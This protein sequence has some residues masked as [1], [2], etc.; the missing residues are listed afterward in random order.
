MFYCRICDNILLFCCSG[1]MS[2]FMFL[3]EHGD[4]QHF[5]PYWPPLSHFMIRYSCLSKNRLIGVHFAE[6]IHCKMSDEEVV[7]EEEHQYVLVFILL[8]IH[9]FKAIMLTLSPH[10]Q[11]IS[12][13][14]IAF[15]HFFTCAEAME[16]VRKLH[17]YFLFALKLH[18][19]QSI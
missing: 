4:H 1:K 18:V 14:Q 2:E 19:N 9:I 5:R 13:L 8:Y 11:L 16:K 12:F 3:Y 15:I 17:I 10:L 7:G 6:F